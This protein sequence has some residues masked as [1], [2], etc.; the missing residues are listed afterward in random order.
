MGLKEIIERLEPKI[1]QYLT[2][3][4]EVVEEI[5][6]EL[7][8]GT[9][10]RDEWNEYYI[11]IVEKVGNPIMIEMIKGF[12]KIQDITIKELGEDNV[13][14]YLKELVIKEKKE[15]PICRECGK[16]Q[17]ECF[18]A[19]IKL[20]TNIGKERGYTC[21]ECIVK[22]LKKKRLQKLDDIETDEFLDGEI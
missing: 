16:N 9:M 21:T 17:D 19:N 18:A 3:E 20:K 7:F 13:I 5:Y 15:E 4:K 22:N 6:K 8:A 11:T 14:K 12:K 2:I 1:I 10:T